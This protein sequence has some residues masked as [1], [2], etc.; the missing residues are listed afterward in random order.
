MSIENSPA[1]PLATPYSVPSRRRENAGG[2]EFDFRR[3]W[4]K[5]EIFRQGVT[6]QIYFSEADQKEIAVAVE[7]RSAFEKRHPKPVAEFFCGVQ[8]RRGL[9]AENDVRPTEARR[10]EELCDGHRVGGDYKSRQATTTLNVNF[11]GGGFL[12]LDDVAQSKQAISWHA[13]IQEMRRQR[14]SCLEHG[15]FD[16]PPKPAAARVSG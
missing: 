13:T 12:L 15:Q 2:G 6:G 7:Q 8:H 1:L 16:S 5:I 3:Q 4:T 10:G 14:G 9:Q 11:I